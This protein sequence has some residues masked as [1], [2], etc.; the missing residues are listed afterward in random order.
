MADETPMKRC[1]RGDQCVHP[2]GCWQPATEV[3]FA[4][5]KRHRDGLMYQCKACT[6]AYSKRRYLV[7][8]TELIAYQKGYRAT[9]PDKVKARLRAWHQKNRDRVLEQRRLSARKRYAADPAK[10]IGYVVRRRT[11]KLGLPNTLTTTDWKRALEY[12]NGCCAY[13]GSQQDFWHVIEADHFIPLNSPQCP[14]T[15]VNN[16]LP[17]CKAC[18]TSKSNSDPHEWLI[19]KFGKRRAKQILARIQAY[20]ANLI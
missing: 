6:N 8:R 3:H 19:R 16:V 13:C 15:T 18:N 12:F 4:K 14:G 7:K 9:N 5:N 2:M 10:H 20:F 1:S 17:A 11:R